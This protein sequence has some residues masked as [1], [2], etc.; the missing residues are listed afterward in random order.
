MN[1]VDGFTLLKGWISRF[2]WAAI[3]VAGTVFLAQQGCIFHKE[4]T[5]FVHVPRVVQESKVS[6]SI[7]D[8]TVNC[9]GELLVI[10]NLSSLSKK[11]AEKLAELGLRLDEAGRLI[12]EAGRPSP[13]PSA[14][15]GLEPEEIAALLDEA[16]Q[17]MEVRLLRLFEIKE[18]LPAGLEIA[19]LLNKSG[20]NYLKYR[21]LPETTVTLPQA[22]EFYLDG[23]FGATQV[24]NDLIDEWVQERKLAVGVM[25][26]GLRFAR[27]HLFK[28]YLEF[29]ARSPSG[30]SEAKLFGQ[31]GIR[32]TLRIER[33]KK[34]A[35]PAPG[36]WKTV[37]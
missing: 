32:P 31:V 3:G 10:K 27:L 13:P 30:L 9:E 25:Y 24:S 28:P 8:R 5:V 35:N 11:Q 7:P 33:K 29:G 19:S 18:Q 20:E 37:Q 2:G 22:W 21:P 17:P 34:V 23:A 1:W 16:S 12:D 6:A 14:L 36:P 4:Q 15:E 26:D